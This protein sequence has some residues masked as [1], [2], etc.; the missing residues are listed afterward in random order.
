[1]GWGA[2]PQEDQSEES[3]LLVPCKWPVAPEEDGPDSEAEC[4]ASL[5]P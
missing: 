4:A 3:E 5:W 1:M 2:V